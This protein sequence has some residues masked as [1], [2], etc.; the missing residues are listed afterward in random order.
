MSKP[1]ICIVDDDEFYTEILLNLLEMQGFETLN[2][3]NS[4]QALEQLTRNADLNIDAVI[5]DVMMPGMNGY[6]LC[7]QLRQTEKF[8]FTPILFVSSNSS[9][10]DRMQGY[11]AGGNDY[12]AKP[13]QPE[14]L[15]TK[16]DVSIMNAR[17]TL[18]LAKQASVSANQVQE[19]LSDMSEMQTLVDYFSAIY[20]INN[21]AQLV[22]RLTTAI[23]IMGLQASALVKTPTDEYFSSTDDVRRPIEIELLRMAINGKKVVTFNSDSERLLFNETNMSLLIKSFNM[24][25]SK[26]T[27]E[28]RKERLTKLLKLLMQATQTR[29]D[30]LSMTN[31]HENLSPS[32]RN[33]VNDSIEE[34]CISFNEQLLDMVLD[35]DQEVIIKAMYKDHITKFVSLINR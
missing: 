29:I 26:K 10:D 3:L 32:S 16:L 17:D 15:K 33:N 18:K 30:A 19:M 21:V 8:Q 23:N 7:S 1:T 11:E 5:L 6:E 22:A 14:E 25:K 31:N 20:Q 12:L 34:S 2:F 27:D 28:A 24:T 4:T 35:K 13:V 9:L